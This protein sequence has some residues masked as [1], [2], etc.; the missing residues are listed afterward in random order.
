M[1][2]KES[3]NC[4]KVLRLV[5]NYSLQFKIF[6]KPQ[7]KLNASKLNFYWSPISLFSMSNIAANRYMAGMDGI[8]QQ[9]TIQEPMEA[10]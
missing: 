6:F 4:E 1:L 5:A 2:F 7:N 9:W 3:K 10:L 8:C